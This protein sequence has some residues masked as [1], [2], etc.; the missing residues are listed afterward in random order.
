MASRIRTAGGDAS[1][2]FTREAVT[3]IQ[4]RSHGIPRTISV[5]CDNALVSGFALGRQPVDREL[6]LEV[7]R[8]FD[9][10]AQ[11]GPDAHPSV[12]EDVLNV[13]EG[14]EPAV[15]DPLAAAEDADRSKDLYSQTAASRRFGLF[16]S[17]PR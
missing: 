17:E 14:L 4:D 10:T 7:A 5:I 1:R 8:D 11:P 2:L 15:G 6:V 12:V 9:L 13:D 3:A 16:G